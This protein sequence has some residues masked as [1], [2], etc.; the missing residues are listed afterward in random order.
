MVNLVQI[1]NA[2]RSRELLRGNCLLLLDS[3]QDLDAELLVLYPYPDT[4]EMPVYEALSFGWR[5]G[6]L[7]GFSHQRVSEN[8]PTI[9]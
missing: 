1:G 2:V 6:S 8:K 7:H 3:G 4:S 5:D 9:F